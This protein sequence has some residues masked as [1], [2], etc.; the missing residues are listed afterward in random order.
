MDVLPRNGICILVFVVGFNSL[1]PVSHVFPWWYLHPID[2]NY[3]Y[4]SHISSSIIVNP[5]FSKLHLCLHHSSYPHVIPCTVENLSGCLGWHRSPAYAGDSGT[6]EVGEFSRKMKKCGDFGFHH[7]IWRMQ[8]ICIYICMV[9]YGM[10]W[11]GM[12][13]YVCM[14]VMYVYGIHVHVYLNIMSS[15]RCLHLLG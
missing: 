4:I 5:S 12:L 13:C 6:S 9:W 15:L 2:Y 11:H 1:P 7:Q 8:H 14:Y 10:V 3:I